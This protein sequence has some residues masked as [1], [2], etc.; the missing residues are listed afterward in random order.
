M[1]RKTILSG[2]AAGIFL[3]VLAGTVV[4]EVKSPIES[5]ISL[6]LKKEAKEMKS[7][8]RSPESETMIAKIQE[9]LTKSYL[10]EGN[11]VE[12]YEGLSFEPEKAYEVYTLKSEN[13]IHEFDQKGMFKD[14]ISEEYVLQVPFSNSRDELVGLA[15]FYQNQGEFELA[16]YG[17]MEEKQEV[18][19]NLE[20]LSE[21]VNGQEELRGQKEIKDVKTVVLY[22][23]NTYAI[24]IGTAD[25]EYMIPISTNNVMTQ[26]EENKIYTAEEFIDVLRFTSR[27]GQEN[28]L[29]SDF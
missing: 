22:R 19:T 14:N 15:S 1:L 23:Y 12:L 7:F 11:P 13:V 8:F 21:L 25:A 28:Q 6:G 10:R 20:E 9:N 18:L 16:A 26:L 27:E 2:C 29:G 4:T 5:Q 3:A 17:E 24:Y